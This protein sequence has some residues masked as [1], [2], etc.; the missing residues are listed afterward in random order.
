MHLNISG[1]HKEIISTIIQGHDE[2]ITSIVFDDESYNKLWD[3]IERLDLCN[4]S[5]GEKPDPRFLKFIRKCGRIPF[6]VKTERTKPL[7]ETLGLMTTRF[8]GIRRGAS[9]EFDTPT[10]ERFLENGE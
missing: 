6:V 10:W 1:I 9:G 4:K 8:C 3:E 2:I 5:D 7:F